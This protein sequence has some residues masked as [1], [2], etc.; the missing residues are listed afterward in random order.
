MTGLSVLYGKKT[1][2]CSINGTHTQTAKLKLLTNKLPVYEYGIHLY[3]HAHML[4]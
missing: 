1:C 4:T 2:A 3:K